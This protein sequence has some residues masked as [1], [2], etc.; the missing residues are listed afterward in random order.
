MEF[1]PYPFVHMALKKNATAPCPFTGGYNMN[2]N[3]ANDSLICHE[4][5]PLRL[6]SE[7][8]RGSG[9]IFNFRKSECTPRFDSR[10]KDR[11]TFR[12]RC[13]TH[14]TQGDYTFIILQ[15]AEDEDKHFCMRT[16]DP[17]GNIKEAYLWLKVK[18]D[19]APV[20]AS[21][22]IH[23]KLEKRQFPST[24]ADE[25]DYCTRSMCDTEARKHCTLTCNNCHSENQIGQCAF[26]EQFRGRSH[27]SQ[28]AQFAD[29]ST[30]R[31]SHTSQIVQFAD[32]STIRRS[33]NS[34]MI[35]QFAD[36]TIRRSH[37]SQIAQFADDSTIRRSHN[38]QM[39]AQFADC[40]I[41]RSHNSQMIAQFAD[42]TIRRSHNS[43]MIAQ[44]ADRTLYAR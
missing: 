21:D 17:L 7:C 25:V 15:L 23:L 16:T 44:F 39:I 14:W 19:L 42:H 9:I 5:L 6:E 30:I 18:C 31:R 29:D 24:C 4:M 13:V 2:G 20:P 8:D 12:S 26:Q 35:A 27:T 37:N 34:Q 40:T 10:P 41:R 32:D 38:S 33:H 36:R 28:I 22:F 43:Q 1:D 11:P 3:Y